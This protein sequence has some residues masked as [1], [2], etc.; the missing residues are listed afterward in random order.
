MKRH[1]PDQLLDDNDLPEGYTRWPRISDATALQYGR[2]PSLA[3]PPEPAR[4]IEPHSIE[5]LRADIY[6]AG[7]R[8]RD[9]R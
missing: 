3:K 6:A 4:R 5:S 8:A 2:D 9:A 7:R 1:N